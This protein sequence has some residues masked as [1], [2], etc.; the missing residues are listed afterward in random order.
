MVEGGIVPI[1]NKFLGLLLIERSDL[2]DQTKE[3]VPA[4]VQVSKPMFDF[5]WP[6]RVHVEADILTLFSIFIAFKRPDLI[7]GYA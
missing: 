2:L 6:K 1:G 5:G 7:E 4:V 3:S